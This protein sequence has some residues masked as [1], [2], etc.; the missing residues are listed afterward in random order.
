M[1]AIYLIPLIFLLI[2]SLWQ[3]DNGVTVQAAIPLIG[4]VA[5]YTT[6]SLS[7][8]IHT[9]ITALYNGDSNY[10]INTSPSYTHLVQPKITIS[11]PASVSESV[12]NS[13]YTV[14][15]SAASSQTITVHY[16]TTDGTAPARALKQL[17]YGGE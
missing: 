2:T 14:T 15:L 12:G 8:G 17:N 3:S 7:D 10:N 11:G 1:L 6:S 5:T 4:G 16:S 9:P 13:T